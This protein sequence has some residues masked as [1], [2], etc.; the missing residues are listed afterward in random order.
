MIAYGQFMK[1]DEVVK[2]FGTLDDE[3]KFVSKGGDSSKKYK[4][5]FVFDFNKHILAIEKGKGLP[6]VNVLQDVLKDILDEH[7]QILFPEHY[8]KIIEMTNSQA[9]EKVIEEA[10]SYKRVEVEVTFSNSQDWSD[11]LEEE[12]L[13]TIETEMKDKHIDSITHIEKAAHKSVMSEPTRT[14]MAY[15]GLACKFGNAVIRYK[16]KLGKTETYKMTDSPIVLPIKEREGDT[17]KSGLDFALDVKESINKA[18][19]L[20]ISAKKLFR[21]LREGFNHEKETK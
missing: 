12:I 18:D 10:E 16:D 13:R 4:F 5:R 19:Q 15:L 17:D 7:R 11:A 8:V 1:F 6:T 3:E 9:L 2:V 14:A 21:K 20:A